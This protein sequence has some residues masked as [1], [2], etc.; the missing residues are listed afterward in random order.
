[1]IEHPASVHPAVAIPVYKPELSAAEKIS[2][3]RTV[4][5]LGR[6]P[7]Y[8]VGPA[9]MAARWQALSQR[10]G[11][12]IQVKTFADRFFCGIKGYNALMRSKEFYRAFAGCSHVLIAQTDA[13]VISDQLGE[14]CGRGYS[15]VGAPWFV[16]GSQP[17]LPLEFYGVGNGGFSLR[18]IDDFLHVLNTPRRIPNFIKSRAE[19]KAGLLGL[20]RRLK[21][22]RW[23]AYNVGPFFPTSNED[24]FWGMLVP[25]VFPF[26]RVPAPQAAI[27]F[28]FEVAPR[29]LYELN[30]QTLPF[31]CHAWERCDRA[32]WEEKL[33]FLK[34]AP[35]G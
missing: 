31:G 9:A 8:L 13:L 33:P 1:M 29:T 24:H 28:A 26:F 15:Y 21:H 16:G 5:A 23:F 35:A 14:W 7:L 34:P 20:P 18:K 32:F 10:Y 22:E 11:Q 17:T 2:V 12:R 25:A 19:G 4:E 27:G 30:G 6:W 3:D